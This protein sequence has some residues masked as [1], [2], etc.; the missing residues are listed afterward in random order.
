MK[1]Q[2]AP[3][4]RRLLSVLLTSAALVAGGRCLGLLSAPATLWTLGGLV[5][6]F[7]LWTRRAPPLALLGQRLCLKVALLRGQWHRRRLDGDTLDVRR[8][9][10]ETLVQHL[11]ALARTQHSQRHLLSSITDSKTFA[12]RLPL[13]DHQHHR[14][15]EGV[16]VAPLPLPTVS[17][18]C[19]PPSL[20]PSTKDTTSRLFLPGVSVCLDAMKTAFPATERL[21]PTARF[22][23]P[24]VLSAPGPSC[25][26]PPAVALYLQLLL[27]LRDPTVG[28]LESS[29][30]STILFAFSVLQERWQDLVEDVELGRVGPRVDVDDGIRSNVNKLLY[31]DPGRAAQLRAELKGGFRGVALRLWPRLSVVLTFDSGSEQIH[32][33]LL[34]RHYCQGVPFYSALY[35]KAQGLIGVNLWPAEEPRRYL[36]CPRSL[37]CEFIP[38]DSLEGGGAPVLRMDQVRGGRGYEL[39]VTNASGHYRFRTGDVLKVVRF[40]NQ[41]PVVELQYRRSQTLNLRREQISEDVFLAAL[42]RAVRL[43]PGAVLVDYCCAQSDVLGQSCGGSDPHYQVFLELMGV[44][45]L[46][47]EQRYKLDQCLQEDSPVYKSLRFKGS[48]GPMRVHLVGGGTFFHWR[49]NSPPNTLRAPRVLRQGE[50][51]H[52]LLGRVVS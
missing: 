1:T 44:R 10:E 14:K 16:G 3:R 26:P 51:V 5:F 32:G 46:S 15:G 23:C 41:C 49:T 20:L 18:I 22:S 43:W 34:R 37:F 7:F 6:L 12:Q 25:T 31:P 33:E 40:F 42:K 11:H 29:F 47:E 9:Q 13:T 4:S 24:P 35:A 27:A 30:A 21:Q 52:F 36:L 39:V 48:I 28:S 17:D 8:A 2:A 50:H 19:G 38:E 45:S